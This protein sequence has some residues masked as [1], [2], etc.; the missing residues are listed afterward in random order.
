MSHVLD[1]PVICGGVAVAAL[2]RIRISRTGALGAAAFVCDKVPVAILV[3]QG[4]LV[5]AMTPEGDAMTRQAIDALCPGALARF[6]G[7][8][9]GTG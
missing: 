6:A 5:R 7:L 1:T 4:E 9:G 8:T 3:R 2:S